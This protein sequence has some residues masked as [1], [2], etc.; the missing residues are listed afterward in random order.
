MRK[1]AVFE[2]T[3]DTIGIRYMYVFS[4]DD[5]V[6]REASRIRATLTPYEL[7]INNRICNHIW[8]LFDVET[9]EL[10]LKT[11]DQLLLDTKNF[12]VV[13]ITGKNRVQELLTNIRSNLIKGQWMFFYLSYA[14]SVYTVLHSEENK[15]KKGKLTYLYHVI[16]TE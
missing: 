14:R 4:S 10:Y 2:E 13:P 11:K 3:K 1:I 16:D 15:G 5:Q 9:R 6:L 12:F 7:S 8:S